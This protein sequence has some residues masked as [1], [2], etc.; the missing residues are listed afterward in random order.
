MGPDVGTIADSLAA[1]EEFA[2]ANG[3]G[4]YQVDQHSLDAFRPSNAKARGWGTVIHHPD[5]QVVVKPFFF[6][7]HYTHDERDRAANDKA[8]VTYRSAYEHASLLI[9]IVQMNQTWSR[10]FPTHVGHLTES[11]RAAVVRR[12]DDLANP[13]HIRAGV[14]AAVDDALAGR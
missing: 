3:P 9:K 4:C 6:G 10:D 1:L 2:R 12:M 5:G 8:L 11:I 7:N 14:K 13:T